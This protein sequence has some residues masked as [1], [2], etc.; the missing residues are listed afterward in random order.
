MAALGPRD[1]KGYSQVPRDLLAG[2]S[3]RS[4]TAFPA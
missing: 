2:I 1:R 3:E 4:R